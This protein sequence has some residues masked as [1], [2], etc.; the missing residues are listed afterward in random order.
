MVEHTRRGTRMNLKISRS[1]P[2]VSGNTVRSQELHGWNL[3][4]EEQSTIESGFL[5]R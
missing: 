3:V 5:H 1:D 2:F 4:G